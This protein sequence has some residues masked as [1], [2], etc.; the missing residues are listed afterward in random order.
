MF[1]NSMAFVIV[2]IGCAAG[3][4]CS[5]QSDL[6]REGGNRP[7]AEA[8]A[9]VEDE[10]AGTFTCMGSNRMCTM[11]EVCWIAGGCCEHLPVNDAGECDDGQPVGGGCVGRCA[12]PISSC[13]ASDAAPAG[14]E[15][16]AGMTCQTCPFPLP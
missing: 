13:V 1:H 10:D 8:S 7:S 6:R 14:C 12:L 9:E 3:L 5:G 2:L 16:M 4:A 15:N 11:T